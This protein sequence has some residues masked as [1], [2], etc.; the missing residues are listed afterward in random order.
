MKILAQRPTHI[1][2]IATTLLITRQ[3]HRE[4]GTQRDRQTDRQRQ[5]DRQR[6]TESDRERDRE[7]EFHE[8]TESSHGAC[9]YTQQDTLVLS[10]PSLGPT[11]S[12][13]PIIMMITLTALPLKLEKGKVV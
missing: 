2:A 5:R 8:M 3:A 10:W 4:T 11:R 6:Q 1:S 7:R 12:G 9:S 13:S